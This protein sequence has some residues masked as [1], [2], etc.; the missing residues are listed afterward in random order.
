MQWIMEWFIFKSSAAWYICLM[1]LSSSFLKCQS[2][3][4]VQH[5]QPRSERHFNLCFFFYWHIVFFSFQTGSRNEWA[6]APVTVSH[7]GHI[8]SN[9]HQINSCSF[10]HYTQMLLFIFSSN[11]HW[12]IAQLFDLGL[13]LGNCSG[14][15][16]GIEVETGWQWWVTVCVC[17]FMFVC[18]CD[19][20]IWTVRPHCM[21][22]K[23]HVSHM[24][25]LRRTGSWFITERNP[26]QPFH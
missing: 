21:L 8:K 20:D 3:P 26:L 12:S 4:A 6:P 2:M 25:G 10:T 7:F 14:W 15:L 1:T 23:E 17:F 9:V 22:H 13:N 16:G 5:N 18:V 24:V 11:V 19:W